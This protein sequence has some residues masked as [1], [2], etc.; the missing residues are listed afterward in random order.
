[1]SQV[2]LPRSS[3]TPRSARQT[4]RLTP[5]TLLRCASHRWEKCARRLA[6]RVPQRLHQREPPPP[7][8]R[9]RAR[10]PHSPRTRQPR[11]RSGIAPLHR[12]ISF[13]QSSAP[14]SQPSTFPSHLLQ[15]HVNPEL[16]TSA[17]PSNAT[18]WPQPQ[19]FWPERFL[20]S[21]S[22]LNNNGVPK[23]EYVTSSPTTSHTHQHPTNHTHL[24]TYTAS[25]PT[26]LSPPAST[27]ASE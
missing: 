15:P 27:P 3:Q 7:H 14:V 10:P 12:S 26:T 11:R 8:H 19:R 5:Q 25:T 17:Q 20:A 22:P 4:R 24:A 21:D 2:L 16:T 6:I 9:L 1:M 18:Y 23:A 13:I